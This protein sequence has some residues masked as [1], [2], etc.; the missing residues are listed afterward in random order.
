MSGVFSFHNG[1]DIVARGGTAVVS[2]VAG[3]VLYAGLDEIIVAGAHHRRFQYWHLRPRVW[4]GEHVLALQTV[5]GVVRP[6]AG[7]V[8]LT[9]IRGS[10]VVNPLAPDHLIPYRDLRPPR[11]V[12]IL[13]RS[14]EGS[15][16]DPARVAQPFEL[17]AVAED[18][19][20][21]SVPGLW[22]GMPVTPALVRWRLTAAGG[23]VIVRE[24]T[25]A[26]FR[27]TVPPNRDFW[28]VY[29]AGTH[30][31]FPELPGAPQSL[32]RG[33]YIFRLTPASSP[34]SLR[35]GSYTVTVTATD[36]GGNSDALSMRMIVLPPRTSL[37]SALPSEP[38]AA[39][40]SAR[41]DSV[42]RTAL[43]D[44]SVRRP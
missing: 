10:C 13:V 2:V 5:L 17:D 44:S 1:V 4:A 32:Q 29:A 12:A 36:T 21:P 7:H 38:P 15:A 6:G 28:Q 23:A 24:R 20:W 34:L 40:R 25:V 35:P 14:R 30:E 8:H 26:D 42:G 18:Y 43:G 3:T 22:H 9:E 33:R 37:V 16:L 39:P 31:N 19:P 27:A 11:V 41:R